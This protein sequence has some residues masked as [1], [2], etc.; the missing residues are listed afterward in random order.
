MSS[1]PDTP[2][3][4]VQWVRSAA[5]YVYQFRARTFVVAFG[6]EVVAD[7]DFVNFVHDLNLLSSLGVRLVL[8]HGARPQIETALAARGLESRFQGSMRVTDRES[9]DCVLEAS[10]RVRIEIEARLSM[11]LANSPMANARIDVANG[12]YVTAKPIGVL[13]GVDM[14][15]TG[16][17]RKIDEPAI[18]ASL[19][20]GAIVLASTYGYS[21][22]GE[23]FN[24]TLEE[25][26]TRTAIALRANK[27]IF[28][29]DADGVVNA[30]GKV[31]SE[32]STLEAERFAVSGGQ[33]GDVAL[34]LPHALRAC[35][36]GVR[37]AHLIPWR[38]DGAIL[39]ELFTREGIGTML[40][41]M[42]L[43]HLR[44]ATI[45]D[46]G[47]ILSLLEP[48]EQAGVLVRRSRELLENEIDR[49]IVA[50]HDEMIIGCAALYPFPAERAGELAGLAVHADFRNEGHGAALLRAIEARAR[51]QGMDRL[52]V[53]TTRTAHWFVEHGF[54]VSSVTALPHRKQALYNLQRRSQV[55]EKR[56]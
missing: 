33:P 23:V 30:D 48:L 43:D 2:L 19:E 39:E 50:E 26:A 36:E 12:N 32:L 41:H 45:E 1:T 15:Y 40:A 4:F 14:Q 47:G 7:E 34:Y 6:G 31:V 53:L 16:E 29:T 20:R 55:Y 42:K 38:R 11:G 28:M 35:R 9:L 8:V 21:P 25:V 51:D 22:T 46:V 13:D 5:P 44:P 18:T 27:L 3:P 37:R 52:F 56:I 54:V 17:V 24:L 10:A 49:F